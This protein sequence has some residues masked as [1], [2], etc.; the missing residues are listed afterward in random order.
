MISEIKWD[1]IKPSKW[2]TINDIFLG[3]ER[4]VGHHLVI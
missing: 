4:V 3:K 1:S 2:E